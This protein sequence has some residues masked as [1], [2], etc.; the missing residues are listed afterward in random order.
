MP[1][2]LPGISAREFAGTPARLLI[3][4][5]DEKFFGESEESLSVGEELVLGGVL[6]LSGEEANGDWRDRDGRKNNGNQPDL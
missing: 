3:R 6:G 1:R 5:W 4:F 2:S